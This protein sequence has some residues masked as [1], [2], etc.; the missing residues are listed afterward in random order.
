MKFKHKILMM[1]MINKKTNTILIIWGNTSLLHCSCSQHNIIFILNWWMQAWLALI[2]LRWYIPI[3]L[4][5]K[6]EKYNQ[7]AQ[8]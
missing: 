1:T 8:H 5:N 3:V 2:I 6:N 7:S 4:L